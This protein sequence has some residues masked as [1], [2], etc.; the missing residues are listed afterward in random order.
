MENAFGHLASRFRI[1]ST[2]INLSPQKVQEITLTCC[3]LHN[4]LKKENPIQFYDDLNE[5]FV[6]K[7][8]LVQQSGNR[9]TRSS[10]DTREEFK[11]YFNNED[12]IPWQYD[13]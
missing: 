2:T 6:F 9:S 11:N 1:F 5:S 7:F 12:A 10:L 4:F 3:I 8:G 13:K